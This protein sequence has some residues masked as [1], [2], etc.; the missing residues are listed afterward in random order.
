MT[1]AEA[2]KKATKRTLRHGARC[3]NGGIVAR[4]VDRAVKMGADAGPA[5]AHCGQRRN[6]PLVEVAEA[7]MKGWIYFRCVSSQLVCCFYVCPIF[8]G[9]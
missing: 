7:L 2:K 9:R 3:W 8:S 4:R 6:V 1:P 5:E